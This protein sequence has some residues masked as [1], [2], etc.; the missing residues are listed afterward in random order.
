MIALVGGNNTSP[1]T[2]FASRRSIGITRSASEPLEPVRGI[3][4]EFQ[5]RGTT[6]DFRVSDI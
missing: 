3:S 5:V 1:D 2:I 4:L 6:A